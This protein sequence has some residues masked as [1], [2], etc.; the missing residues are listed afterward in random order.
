MS[1]DN[2]IPFGGK[3][4]RLRNLD[5]AE[6][7]LARARGIVDL[8]QGAAAFGALELPSSGESLAQALGTVRDLLDAAFEGIW[9]PSAE[10]V[11]P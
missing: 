7:A 5:A 10:G 9:P 8:L 3:P 4:A 1:T 2:V 11:Q 6:V